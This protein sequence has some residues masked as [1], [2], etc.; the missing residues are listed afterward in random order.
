MVLAMMTRIVMEGAVDPEEEMMIGLEEIGT[1]MIV[2]GMRIGLAE[3]PT[4]TAL[5]MIGTVVIESVPRMTGVMEVEAE[6]EDITTD[7]VT[8]VPPL[9][10]RKIGRGTMT[11]RIGTLAGTSVILPLA[12]VPA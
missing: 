10:M 12:P 5:E 11:K 6:I 3:I 8:R 7:T 9:V 1:E 4:A 2:I